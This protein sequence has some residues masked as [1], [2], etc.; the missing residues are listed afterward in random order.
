MGFSRS[1]LGD[2]TEASVAPVP[3]DVKVL[4]PVS[5]LLADHTA[6]HLERLCSLRQLWHEQVPAVPDVRPEGEFHGQVMPLG[7]ICQSFCF[8]S[9]YIMLSDQH[10]KR[11]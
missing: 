6:K 4:S 11:C 8:A 1:H 9:K 5:S 7:G 2:Q 10:M 3:D